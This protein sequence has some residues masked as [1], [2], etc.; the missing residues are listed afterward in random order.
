MKGVIFVIF[1]DSV[2]LYIKKGAAG[3]VIDIRFK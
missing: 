2:A 1:H 3:T